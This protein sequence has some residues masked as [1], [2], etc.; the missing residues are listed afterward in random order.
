MQ[1]NQSRLTSIIRTLYHAPLA[2][3]FESI[4]IGAMVG[5][6]IVLFRYLLNLAGGFRQWIYETLPHSSVY[7]IGL[8]TVALALVGLFLGMANTRW[9]MIKGGGVSQVKGTL[10]GNLSMHWVPELPMKIIT[11][12]L[13]LGAGLSMGREG[14]AIQ[15]GAYVGQ[16]MLSVFRR[17]PP[18]RKILLI[19]A[20]AAGMSAAF[21][22]PLAGV[23]FALEE[24]LP[25]FSPLFIACIMGASMAADM[26]VGS[27]W[28][29]GPLL[30]F[31]NINVLPVRMFPGI[32][33]LGIV[34]AV[35]G[36][37]YKRALYQAGDLYT[38]LRIPEIIRPIIPLVVTVPLGFV[39]FDLLGDGHELIES[40][41]RHERTLGIVVLLLAGKI[42]FTAFC[43]GSGTSGGIFVPLLACGALAGSGIGQLLFMTGFVTEGQIL[44][45]LILGM[46]AFFTAV[47]KAPVTGI[48]LILE[49]SGSIK[50]L[51]G[52]VVVCLATFVTAELMGSRPVYEVLLERLLHQGG[53]QR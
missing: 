23:L 29:L 50:H 28:G 36:D 24:L 33:L 12:L 48:V 39:F 43:S 25:S 19:A 41:S 11:S 51:E 1:K 49:M 46:A 9:P 10:L 20:S 44:N 52:L 18:V 32:I 53:K 14:P 8:W 42:L 13:G 38:T 6:V 21:T 26:V 31:G 5:L 17:P 7:W 45:F 15:I 3:I 4:I 34:C 35:L 22:A 47:I 40:L 30:D 2:V 27:F 16:G 37:I